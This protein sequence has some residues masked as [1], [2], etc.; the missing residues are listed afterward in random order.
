MLPKDVVN[1]VNTLEQL[2][3]GSLVSN[4]TSQVNEGAKQAINVAQPIF[5]NAIR[6]ITISDAIQLVNGGQNSITNFF[7]QKT[8]TEL[9]QAFMPIVGQKL[10]NTDALNTY[11]RIANTINALPISNNKV[12]TDLTEFVAQ[13]AMNAMFGLIAQEEVNIRQNVA[14]RTSEVLQTVFANPGNF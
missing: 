10:N 5:N 2:G 9:I 14:A 4:L 1:V 8:S 13:Q 6:N 7:K 11:S 3:L 12:S